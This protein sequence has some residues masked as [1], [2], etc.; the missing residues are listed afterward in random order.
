MIADT[1]FQ[2]NHA[3]AI[4]TTALLYQEAERRGDPKR[5]RAY[6]EIARL[7]LES[8]PD[9]QTEAHRAADERQLAAA[10]R[11]DAPVWERSP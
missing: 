3:V 2:H 6:Q 4:T 8:A 1:W 11:L 10:M 7:L 5:M 9:R